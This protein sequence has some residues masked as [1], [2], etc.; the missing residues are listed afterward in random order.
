MFALSQVDRL[1]E[2]ENTRQEEKKEEEY[3]PVVMGESRKKMILFI[4]I[5]DKKKTN[6][7]KCWLAFGYPFGCR[8]RINYN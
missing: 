3:K 5:C 8:S 7:M 6:S 1:V 2:S 4:S